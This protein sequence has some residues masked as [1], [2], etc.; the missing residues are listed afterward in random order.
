MH[1]NLT[2]H[3]IEVVIPELERLTEGSE[4]DQ[5]AI[6][7]LA[8]QNGASVGLLINIAATYVE[9]AANGTTI[10]GLPYAGKLVK[11]G[12]SNE[13]VRAF[14]S[15]L[16]LVEES[17]HGTAPHVA[18]F[19]ADRKAQEV[20]DAES[21]LRL[22][23]AFAD[24]NPY[25]LLKERYTTILWMF[26][27][28]RNAEKGGS[29]HHGNPKGGEEDTLRV[30]SRAAVHLEYLRWDDML[31]TLMKVSASAR[32]VAAQRVDCSRQGLILKGYALAGGLDHESRERIVSSVY[33]EMSVCI[34]KGDHTTV[35]MMYRWLL[36]GVYRRT[37]REH[38]EFQQGMMVL[39][40]L[41][42]RNGWQFL[43]ATSRQN[44]RNNLSDLQVEA[45]TRTG[46]VVLKHLNK[47]QRGERV[48]EGDE[49]IVHPSQWASLSP[50]FTGPKIKIFVTE[51]HPSSP[52]SRL[53]K[54]DIRRSPGR[55]LM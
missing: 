23:L 34:D 24:Q 14:V 10:T 44:P 1:N 29:P 51:L 32:L 43:P 4:S 27:E 35:T 49:I 15:H 40:G 16:C 8:L 12:Y 33:R 7:D 25:N 48:K 18:G 45:F 17:I 2:D 19:W 38:Y 54:D 39:R 6:F 41:L 37:G 55:D 13:D 47:G 42:E 26:A 31:E 50:V 53:T 46:K 22:L 52:P 9:Y 3:D 21:L 36:E 5:A 11:A 20:F 30:M 28:R